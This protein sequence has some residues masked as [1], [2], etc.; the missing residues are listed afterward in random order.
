MEIESVDSR[1]RTNELDTTEE[2]HEISGK[3]I[4]TENRSNF[5]HGIIIINLVHYIIKSLNGQKFCKLL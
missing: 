3:I 5:N 4:Y 2:D 1:K